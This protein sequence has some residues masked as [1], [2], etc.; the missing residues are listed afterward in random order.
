MAA[1]HFT[2]LEDYY[3]GK[4]H[5]RPCNAVSDGSVFIIGM[6]TVSGIFGNSIWTRQLFDASALSIA[7]I[8][9]LTIG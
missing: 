1:F 8:E 4:L 5:L 7:G 3:I 2:T 9:M 6:H